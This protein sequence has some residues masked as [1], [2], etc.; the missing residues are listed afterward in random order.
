MA[1]R[2]KKALLLTTGIAALGG[3]VALGVQAYRH[4]REMM[5]RTLRT[6]LLALGVRE[7]TCDAA[8][9]PM[10][11]YSA[12]RRGSPLVL[13]HGLGSSAESWT[14][15]MPLLGRSYLVY[16]PDLP[17]FGQTPMAPEGATIDTYVRYLERFLD[18]LGYPRVVLA[19]NSLG[20]WIA[21]RFAVEHPER[22]ERLY[23]LNSAGL[24]RESMNPPYATDRESARRTMK[25][26][27][28]YDLPL[29]GFV[30]DAVVRNSQSPAYKQFFQ[31]YRPQDDLDSVLDQ[32]RAPTTI[33]W[34]ERD[35]IFPIICA[36]DL[37]AGIPGSELIFL[38]RVAHMAQLQAPLTVARIM[39]NGAQKPSASLTSAS[40]G[41]E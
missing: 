34:G 6:G 9:V 32:V 26:L 3:A 25:H 35:G 11:Y 23:L 21:A 28:G 31:H 33:I 20:G 16:A 30:L 36:R 13:I 10:R 15:L 7:G 14:A 1:S 5:N 40:G 19:G 41:K 8:G 4:P 27:W 29:P 12:G 24:S 17:G 37:H 39:L 2:A 18:C 38:P 22:V